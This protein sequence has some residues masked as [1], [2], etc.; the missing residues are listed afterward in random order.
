MNK[1]RVKKT[2]RILSV[3]SFLFSTAVALFCFIFDE[4]NWIV[5]FIPYLF[6]FMIGFLLRDYA[7][8]I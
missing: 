5:Y 4:S 3:I 1:N 6:F 7:R 2:L 8:E